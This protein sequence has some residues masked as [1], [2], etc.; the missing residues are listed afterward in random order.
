[1]A[2]RKRDIPSEHIVI[3]HTKTLISVLKLFK[4][5][6]VNCFTKE[7]SKFILQAMLQ[8]KSV[9]VTCDFSGS[10]D[11]FCQLSAFLNAKYL[12]S[13]ISNILTRQDQIIMVPEKDSVDII[14]GNYKNKINKSD[15]NDL[16][17]FDISFEYPIV[18]ELLDFNFF[19]LIYS[20]KEAGKE[21]IIELMNKGEE[22]FLRLES[23]DESTTVEDLIPVEIKK[24]E[25]EF[26]EIFYCSA[27]EGVNLSSCFSNVTISLCG[28]KTMP[29]MEIYYYSPDIADNVKCHLSCKTNESSE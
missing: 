4:D 12:S 8:T 5:T 22:K 25:E 11:V 28:N 23:T 3:K 15:A 29:A 18:L 26:K 6:V 2:K 14:C 7:E 27:I 9:M 20:R 17:E 10:M 19:S 24:C 13:A 21:V 16:E 1:M